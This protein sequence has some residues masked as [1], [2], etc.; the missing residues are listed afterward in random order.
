MSNIKTEV[1][2]SYEEFVKGMMDALTRSVG[3]KGGVVMFRYA[4]NDDGAKIL[5]YHHTQ[6]I[7]EK[8]A[9][10]DT[11]ERTVSEAKMVL[12]L[13]ISDLDKG[14]LGKESETLGRPWRSSDG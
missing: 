8:E 10:L 14:R 9:H 2:V 4:L 1:P 13:A 5:S 7:S 11:R 12:N 3:R 6:A